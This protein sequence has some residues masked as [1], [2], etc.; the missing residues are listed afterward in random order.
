MKVALVHD[1]LTQ[2][3]GAEQ[4]LSV[5][6]DMYPEA[7]IFTLLYDKDRIGSRFENREIRPSFLQRMP[8]ARKHERWLLPFMPGATERHKVGGYDV[9]IS[10][11]S[12][13]AKGV[14][15]D[16]RSVHICYCHTPTR[17]LWSDTVAY[18]RDLPYPAPIKAFVPPILSKLRLWDRQAA[19]RPDVM[20]ANS[21]TVRRRIQKYY[22]RDAEVIYPPVN[23]DSF[24]VSNT[25]KSYYLTG[26][27]L[28][29]YKRFDLVVETFNRLRLPLVIFGEGP[30]APMLKQKAKSNI[31]F[32]GFTGAEELAKLYAQAKAFIHPQEEDFGITA[33]EAMASGRP[34]IAYRG[35]GATETVKEGVSGLF[36]D[37]QNWE[38]LAE[39][40]IRFDEKQFDPAAVRAHT[41][42]F[43]VTPFSNH[44]RRVVEQSMS[45]LH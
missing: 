37:E 29:P 18:V 9:V 43:G 16:D 40:I 30:M 31:T 2:F 41:E 44:I 6:A 14:L 4:V 19:E 25:P 39:A 3:G 32:V 8:G 11:S 42:Q 28:V 26:G 21:D 24:A 17:Y 23:I 22:R 5:L 20:L 27:R 34:V 45:S 12:A 38:T 36:F 33:V 1:H 35:G 15:T 10:S 13:F 7:P